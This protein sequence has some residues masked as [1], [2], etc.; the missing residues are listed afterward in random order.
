M[1]RLVT[2]AVDAFT[3]EACVTLQSECVS[4]AQRNKLIAF[5]S[6]CFDRHSLD[7]LAGTECDGN[8]VF[9]DLELLGLYSYY[10][11]CFI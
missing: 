6:K 4:S 3:F 5:P 1:Y 10:G 8:A 2:V 9:L 11:L 7:L